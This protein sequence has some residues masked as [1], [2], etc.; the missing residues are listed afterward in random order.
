MLFC[1]GAVFS[2]CGSRVG[3][4]FSSIK[5]VLST[6]VVVQVQLEKNKKNG[7]ILK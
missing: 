6:L 1:Q 3:E 4:A 7:N 2:G 5:E